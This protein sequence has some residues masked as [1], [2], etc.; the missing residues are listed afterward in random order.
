M[1]TQERVKELF[2]YRDGNL[3]WR[4]DHSSRAR[5]GCVAGVVGRRGYIRIVVDGKK[6]Y[7]HRLVWL[8][9]YGYLPENDIDHVNKIKSYNWVENLREVSRRCNLRNKGNPSTNKSGVK[10]VGWFKRDGNWRAQIAVNGNRYNL[11]YSICFIEAV[12][13]RLCAEQ[14]ESWEGCDSNSPAY[15]FMQKYI[16]RN[17]ICQE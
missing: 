9:H 7:A 11:G 5:K 16:N 12:A 8:W 13:I 3:Y 4:E 15:Q 2:D 10:G 17:N 1:L 6:F 14:F